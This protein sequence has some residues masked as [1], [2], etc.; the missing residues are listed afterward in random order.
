M[1]A[2]GSSQVT[3]A[4]TVDRGNRSSARL[5]GGQLDAC[6]G[7]PRN[8]RLQGDLAAV[9]VN[10]MGCDGQAEPR[11]IWLAAGEHRERIETLRNS[12]PIV[13]DGNLRRVGGRLLYG[14]NYPPAAV[15]GLEARV[16]AD[17]DET[18]AAVLAR[19]EALLPETPADK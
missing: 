4:A 7:P 5:G 17:R 15:D 13:A 12:D 11:P 3:V 14:D 10:E 8:A 2:T 9:D 6:D 19:A 1:P 16:R 18:A